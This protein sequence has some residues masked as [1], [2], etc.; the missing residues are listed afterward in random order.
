[1]QLKLLY[2][3]RLRETLG[4]PGEAL[5]LPDGGTVATLLAL[6]R[7]RGGPGHRE[8]AS[9]RAVRIASTITGGTTA[10]WRLHESRFFRPYGV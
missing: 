9:G 10:V 3:A 5:E 2:L 4:R 6:L 8:L 1:M 7:E